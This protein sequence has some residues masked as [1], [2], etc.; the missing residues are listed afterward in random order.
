MSANIRSATVVRKDRNTLDLHTPLTRRMEIS[1]VTHVAG[2]HAMCAKK[3]RG[4]VRPVSIAWSICRSGPARLVNSQ[5][6]T[7]VVR[8]RKMERAQMSNYEPE[9]DK[10]LICHKFRFPP[11]D[12]CLQTMRPTEGRYSVLKK[13]SWTCAVCRRGQ[14]SLQ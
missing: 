13:P 6:V 4:L 2:H 7:C 5:G 9:S 3:R 8:D 12:V 14:R 11:C 1:F 10:R